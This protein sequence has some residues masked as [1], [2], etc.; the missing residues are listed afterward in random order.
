MSNKVSLNYGF[1]YNYS[2]SPK[3][4]NQVVFSELVSNS[5]IK[6]ISDED[7]G[8]F[9]INRTTSFEVGDV[10]SLSLTYEEILNMVSTLHLIGLLNLTKVGI[11]ANGF[12]ALLGVYVCHV[13]GLDDTYNSSIR[14]R[15]FSSFV[16]FLSGYSKGINSSTP[17]ID[18]SAVVLYNFL[19]D[20][21][22][23]GTDRAFD[24]LVER[25]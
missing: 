5:T 4:N 14:S 22:V 18:K 11:D 16:T 21:S 7:G 9:F 12:L 8:I 2:T 15:R 13:A 17:V 1:Y 25:Y 3:S 23:L 6:R 10:E 24:I 20:K 19:T